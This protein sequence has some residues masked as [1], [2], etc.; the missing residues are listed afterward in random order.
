[1]LDS[2]VDDLGY[3]D[4]RPNPFDRAELWRGTEAHR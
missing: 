1:M 2:N 3:H 4:T